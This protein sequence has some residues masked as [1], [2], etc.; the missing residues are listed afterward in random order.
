M[1]RFTAIIGL[2]FSALGLQAATLQQL[3]LEE[4]AE[5]A[6]AI[7]RGRVTGSSAAFSGATIY[8][9][10]K[11]EVSEA[12]KGRAAAEVM[13]PGGTVNR[14]RQNYPGVPE[15][16]PGTDYVLFLWTSPSSGV[17]HLLGLTQGL[18]NV[19]TGSDG[20]AMASRLQTGEL[21]LDAQGRRV[22][23]QAVTMRLGDMRSRVSVRLTGGAAK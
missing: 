12:W 20:V 16:A 10:Y 14:T 19:S 2:V 9:H 5:K 6:T 3:S 21:M 13:V 1:S 17:V 23:D 8:T 11:L 7:V 4:M 22:A 18:F 15:L